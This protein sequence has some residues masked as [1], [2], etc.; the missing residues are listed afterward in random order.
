MFSFVGNA[1]SS[2][3]DFFGEINELKLANVTSEVMARKIKITISW[4]A[5]RWCFK[6]DPG[7][8]GSVELRTAPTKN[9]KNELIWANLEPVDFK[10]PNAKLFDPKSTN[11]EYYVYIPQQTLIFNRLT[12][13][14]EAVVEYYK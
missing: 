11:S 4:E 10:M 3:T 12:K 13:T 8:K 7:C 1:Q 9:G 14:F 5:G 2:K 6:D